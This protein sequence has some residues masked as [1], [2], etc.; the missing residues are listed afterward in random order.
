LQLANA[1][2][3]HTVSISDR[4]LIRRLRGLL[5]TTIGGAL[6][7]GGAGAFV[8]LVFL[9]AFGS[10][11][12]AI[13][14]Q[15]PGSVIIVPATLGA[16]VGAVSGAVFGLLL[17]LS[18]RGRGVDDLRASRAAILAAVASFAALRFMGT[19]SW[20]PIA[21]GTTLAAAIGLG[22]TML[23]KRT[24]DVAASGKINPPPT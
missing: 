12:P 4:M 16:I 8:G 7:G 20:L 17:M 3:W 24:G 2:G 11:T 23:S 22:A 13:T 14:P 6:V 1:L 19:W 21:L 15:F 10:K 9:L 18:E 5:A